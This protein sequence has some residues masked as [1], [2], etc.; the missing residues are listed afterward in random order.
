MANA[1]LFCLEL[2]SR[3][4]NLAFLRFSYGV[5]EM[6]FLNKEKI[7]GIANGKVG[8]FNYSSLDLSS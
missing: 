2:F 8:K 3:V 7:N 1:F 6:L 5:T 4:I